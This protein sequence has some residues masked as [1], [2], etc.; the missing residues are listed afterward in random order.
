MLGASANG[1]R[2]RTCV[3]DWWTDQSEPTMNSRAALSPGVAI[4]T[5]VVNMVGAGFSSLSPSV[6]ASTHY[7]IGYPLSFPLEVRYEQPLLRFSRRFQRR[8]TLTC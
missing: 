6:V 5:M 2:R 1:T 4:S 7:Q 3:T 8:I